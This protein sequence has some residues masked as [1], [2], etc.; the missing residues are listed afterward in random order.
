[1]ARTSTSAPRHRHRGWVGREAHGALSAAYRPLIA[2]AR[3]QF[4]GPVRR[5]ASGEAH[6][7]EMSATAPMASPTAT[8]P[9]GGNASFSTNRASSIVPSG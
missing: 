5:L 8:S 1:M 2:R 7:S 4:R 6:P 3:C 9:S